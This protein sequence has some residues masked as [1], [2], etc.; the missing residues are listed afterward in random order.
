VSQR[1]TAPTSGLPGRSGDDTPSGVTDAA[2][3]VPATA[4]D[5]GIFLPDGLTLEKVVRLYIDRTLEQCNG[6]RSLAAQILMIGR[7]TLLRKIA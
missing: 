1:E 4:S 7:N 3:A 2:A 5:S 6:N